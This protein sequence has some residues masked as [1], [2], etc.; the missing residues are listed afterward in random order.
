MPRYR[1]G[2]ALERKIKKGKK[3]LKVWYARIE[4][5]DDSGVKRRIEKKPTYNSEASARDKAR[6]MLAK[7]DSDNKAFDAQAMTFA[8]L[9]D[10]YKKTFLVEP[11]YRDGRKI[12]GLRSKYD[13]EKRLVPLK[14]FFGRKRVRAITHG[15]LEQ[16]KTNRL[17][18]PVVIGRNT[19]GT[20]EKGSPKER[21][22]SIA[23]V[24]RELS[25]LRRILNVAVSNGWLQK[26]PFEMGR[27]LINPGDEKPRER[28]LTREEETRLLAGCVEAKAHLKAIL[29]CALDTGMRRGEMFKLKWSDMDFENGLITIRAFNTKIMRERQVAMTSRLISE[30]LPLSECAE[31]EALVFNV[32][33][34][35]KTAFDKLKKKLGLADLRFHDLRHTHATRLVSKQLPLAEVGRMLGHTQA[36]TTFRYVNAN[37]ET[38]R[39][40][41]AMLDEYNA[42]PTE[43][44][45]TIVH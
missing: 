41:A 44:A 38:A 28:I 13:Y 39:R 2:C 19:R 7:L 34:S 40:A 9:A 8:Q 16:Y 42:P 4:Y 18:T 10:H 24:H 21:D 29:I 6:E 14:T 1:T 12:A 11:E 45:P 17:K 37:V 30:L 22:R 35:V 31:P 36:N 23:T 26:N 15:D 32:K 5:T 20:K 33:T 27:S 43:A 3:T 25:F